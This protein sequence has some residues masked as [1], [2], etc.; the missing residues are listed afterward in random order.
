MAFE[1]VKGIQAPN[2]PTKLYTLSIVIE[3]IGRAHV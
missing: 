3:E 2:K 1:N